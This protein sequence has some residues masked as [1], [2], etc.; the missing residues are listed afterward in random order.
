MLILTVPRLGLAA[1]PMRLQSVLLGALEISPREVTDEDVDRVMEEAKR[2]LWG[3]QTGSGLWPRHHHNLPGGG[4][5]ALAMFALL[6]AGESHNDPRMSKGLEA[7]LGLKTNN[8]YVI[9][10]RVMALSQIVASHKDSPCRGQLEKDLKWLTGSALRQGGAWGYAGPEP[11]GDNSCSQFA[12][13]ALWEADRAGIRINPGLIRLVERIWLRRQRRDGG[14]T[15]PGQPNVAAKSTLTMTTAGLASLFI[16][17][18]VLTKTCQPYPHRRKTKAGWKYLSE[19]LKNDYF[20]NGYLAFCVQRVG[21]ASGRKFIAGMD[22]FATGAAKLAEP[23][24]YGRGYG[25]QW[26]PVVRASFELI[27]LARGRI[28][29]TFN[30]LAHGADAADW[31]FHTRDVPHF[32]EYMRRNFERRMR[33]QIVKI[34]DNIQL[35]LDAPILLMTGRKALDFTPRQ[36]QKL[37]EYTLRG[38][39]LLLI[40]SHNSKAFLAS[41]RAA[42]ATLYAERRRIVAGPSPRSRPA[43]A[44]ATAPAQESDLFTLRQ[45]PEDHPIYTL[46]QKVPNARKTA[47][48]WGVSDGT[49]LLAV[50][51]RR[52]ITCAWQRRAVATGKIDYMLGVNFFLYA[53]GANSLRMRLRPV[54]AGSGGQARRRAKVAWL[55]HPGNWCTQPYAL[56]Y[57][58]A[59]LTA[60]N[61]VAIQT[62]VGAP[63]QADKL[64]GHHLAWM[65]GHSGFSLSRAEIGALRS[66]LDAGGTLFINA[67]GGSREFNLSAREMLEELFAGRAPLIGNAG[68]DSPLVTGRCGEFR[69]PRLEKL[70]RTRAWLKLRQRA[71]LQLR[72]YEEGARAVVIYAPYGV[73]DA[74]DGHTAHAAKSY[75][76]KAA[77]DI[78]ANVVLYA[79]MEKPKTPEKPKPTAAAPAGN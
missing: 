72:L 64:E 45:L 22:W 68:P 40:P 63:L 52:D 35:L 28:P 61:R 56:N 66:Y 15:Y 17:Q 26:G 48:M 39:T 49:R 14:W 78:A 44:P 65:T 54:F 37:R 73:H 34:A 12:L 47:P 4:T 5:T 59:K 51:C 13:L 7:L 19:N 38:G 8:V 1:G 70:P 31:D 46:H 27:F 76:P 3:Q 77:R 71:G 57:L 55:K 58:S 32:T 69:G 43:T 18:D 2:Y 36:W 16:C 41:A 10:T 11:T 79:L 29:L 23:N 9:A 60:E 62:T 21:M 20:R 24:P 50:I 74:L 75:M 30:K 6:E 53:T 33:W 42:L 25:G 67:V